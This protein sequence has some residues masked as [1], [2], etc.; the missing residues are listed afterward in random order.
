MESQLLPVSQ[1]KSWLF[2]L[3]PLVRLQMTAPVW[4]GDRPQPA[5]RLEKKEQ[6]SLLE[7]AHKRG[8][9]F[10][11]SIWYPLITLQ[12]QQDTGH[13]STQKTLPM[14]QLVASSRNGSIF[15]VFSLQPSAAQPSLLLPNPH[16]FQIL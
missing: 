5:S 4:P 15:T 7:S 8:M 14:T 9:S 10:E 11:S 6:Q 16:A 3:R 12:P 13:I 2:F 1:Q